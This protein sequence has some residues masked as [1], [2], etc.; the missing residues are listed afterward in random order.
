MQRAQSETVFFGRLPVSWQHILA[1]VLV[2]TC[3][4]A[5]EKA[6]AEPERAASGSSSSSPG[7]AV[8]PL[9]WEVPGS[10]TVLSGPTSG[11]RKA[12]YN[13]PKAGNDKEDA[14]VSVL[15]YGT[16]ALGDAEKNFAEWFSEFDGNVGATAKRE[17]FEVH[18]WKVETV[19]VAGTYKVALGPKVGPK[20]KSPMQ[21]VKE[22]WRMLGAVVKTP[23]RGNWFVKVVGPDDTV[24]SARSGVRSM[25]DSAK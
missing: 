4:A 5:C 15:F 2:A 6:P 9:V 10:W 24:Q 22:N 1:V 8:T 21:M 12:G 20:K 7:P 3:L 25:L 11:A 14:E 16:G 19:E 17:S 13:I 18:G 23:D